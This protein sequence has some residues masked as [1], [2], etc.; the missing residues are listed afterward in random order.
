M[1]GNTPLIKQGEV[2]QEPEIETTPGWQ[3]KGTGD[4]LDEFEAAV[5]RY[6]RVDGLDVVPIGMLETWIARLRASLEG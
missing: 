1:R 5:Q 2:D 6:R 3:P 4:T